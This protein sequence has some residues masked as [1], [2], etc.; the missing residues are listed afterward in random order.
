VAFIVN[1]RPVVRAGDA[2][3]RTATPLNLVVA[4]VA[5]SF[6]VLFIVGIVVDQYPCWT[7]V[8]NCD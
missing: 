2:W 8:P 1:I 5:L 7:G 6:V 4:V 3:S